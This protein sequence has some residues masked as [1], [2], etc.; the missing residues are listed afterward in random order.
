M[1]EGAR[2]RNARS[3]SPSAQRWLERQKEI[4]NAIERDKA[5]VRQAR[6][7]RKY[8][9]HRDYHSSSALIVSALVVLILLGACWFVIDRMRCDPF[10][11]EINRL[12]RACE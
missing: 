3:A 7:E 8:V 5:Q 10:Y 11:A 6:I 9:A 4:D 2:E 12:S 1:T